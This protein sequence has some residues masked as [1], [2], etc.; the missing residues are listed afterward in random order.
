MVQLKKFMLD[1]L[2]KEDIQKIVQAG[3]TLSKFQV[4]IYDLF[5]G[6]FMPEMQEMINAA[7]GALSEI[8]E[9]RE[10]EYPAEYRKGLDD[11]AMKEVYE[12]G[13]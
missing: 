3:S 8:E 12:N 4:E 6:R 11:Q 10:E 7:F 13:S 2:D 9:A 1:C 5:E